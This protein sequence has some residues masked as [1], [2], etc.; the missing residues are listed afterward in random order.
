MKINNVY[1]ITPAHGKED[2]RLYG[3]EYRQI[4]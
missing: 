4:Q 2:S 1:I 3:D